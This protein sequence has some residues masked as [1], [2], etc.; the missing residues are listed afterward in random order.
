MKMQKMNESSTI[1]TMM[2]TN[3]TTINNNNINIC[4]KRPFITDK[5]MKASSNGSSRDLN[6]QARLSR[7]D[8]FSVKSKSE[9]EANTTQYSGLQLKVFSLYRDMLR[10]S[11]TKDIETSTTT[12]IT[13]T[14]SKEVECKP[15]ILQ[16]Y[17]QEGTN[18]FH[19]RN[20]FRIQAKDLNRREIDRIEH[21]IRQGRKFIKLLQMKGCV[22]FSGTTS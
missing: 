20:Q 22:S 10:A 16:L 21:H 5:L 17:Q 7:I 9:S 11:F 12:I 6:I 3:S 1:S 13:T 19:V 8:E 14:S 18:T 4:N 15:S 2:T